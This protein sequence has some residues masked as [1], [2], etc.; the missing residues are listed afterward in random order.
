MPLAEPEANPVLA[1]VRRLD[2]DLARGYGP[3]L[4][5]ALLAAQHPLVVLTTADRQ[6]QPADLK[7]LLGIIDQVD[8]AVGCR[9][10]APRPWWRR[11]L[12]WVLARLAWVLVGL[13]PTA[14]HLTPGAT[15]W[16]RRWLA[17]GSSR[18]GC[19]IRNVRSVSFAVKR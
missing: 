19:T 7:T 1:E 8:I 16:Q 5:A 15:P 13:P 10:V 11:A 12:G 17:R 9:T 18:C 4:R 6:Y 2:Y 3:A 14:T